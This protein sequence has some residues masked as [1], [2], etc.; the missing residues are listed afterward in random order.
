MKG[1]RGAVIAVVLGVLAPYRSWA[2]EV[3]PLS[4]SPSFSPRDEGSRRVFLE[5]RGAT[6][7][8][9]VKRQA[10]SGPNQLVCSGTCRRELE[11]GPVYIIRTERALIPSTHQFTLPDDRPRVVLDVTPA[12]TLRPVAGWSLLAAGIAA[13]FLSTAML[14]GDNPGG[15]AAMRDTPSHAWVAVYPLGLA[16]AGIG[17]YL[18]GSSGPRIRTDAGTTF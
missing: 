10:S 16:T 14:L 5:I 1:M 8:V 18:L 7:G 13:V 11:P 17:A 2:Q 15:G 4:P 3:A 9:Q 12:P 6:A